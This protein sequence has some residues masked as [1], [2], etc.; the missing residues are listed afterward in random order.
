[1]SQVIQGSARVSLNRAALVTCQTNLSL[2]GG[3]ARRIEK[4]PGVATWL[5]ENA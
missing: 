4:E 5:L 3:D 2:G 1:M